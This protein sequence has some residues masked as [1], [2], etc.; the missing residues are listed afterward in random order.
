MVDVKW[1]LVIAKREIQPSQGSNPCEG[2][3]KKENKLI[4]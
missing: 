4:L 2:S 3:K 1:P